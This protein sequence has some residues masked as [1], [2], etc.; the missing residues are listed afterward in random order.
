MY[1]MSTQG[2]ESHVKVKDNHSYT[3]A[4]KSF[5]RHYFIIAQAATL[6]S[7]PGRIFAFT[8]DLAKFFA[9]RSISEKSAWSRGSCYTYTD[10]GLVH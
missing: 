8:S 6:A 2:I 1:Y 3:T 7:T 10:R 4:G 9:R 5:K